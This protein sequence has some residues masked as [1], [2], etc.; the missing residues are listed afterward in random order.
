MFLCLAENKKQKKT[1]T[2]L[3][4]KGLFPSNE[5]ENIEKGEQMIADSWTVTN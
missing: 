4:S 1:E 3:F 5:N 2:K